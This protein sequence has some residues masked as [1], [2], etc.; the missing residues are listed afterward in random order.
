MDKKTLDKSY[1]VTMY[2]LIKHEVDIETYAKNNLYNL[3]NDLKKE[4]IQSF[5][6]SQCYTNFNDRVILSFLLAND[7]ILDKLRFVRKTNFLINSISY[8]TFKVSEGS[9]SSLSFRCD[10]LRDDIMDSKKP[11][12]KISYLTKNYDYIFV[13]LPCNPSV[14]EYF[15]SLEELDE[16]DETIFNNKSYG[17]YTMD[18]LFELYNTWESV[19]GSEIIALIN[20]YY[21]KDSLVGNYPQFLYI[22]NSKMLIDGTTIKPENHV[23]FENIIG[24]NQYHIESYTFDNGN[25]VGMTVAIVVLDKINS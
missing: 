2:E 20:D 1:D 10:T 4:Y 25:S 9:E 14:K 23:E 13:C 6:D 21:S 22:A 11:I 17:S 24:W 12:D 18:R 15:D 5:I 8:S 3:T 16:K 7:S 19:N